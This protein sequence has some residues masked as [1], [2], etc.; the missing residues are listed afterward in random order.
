MAKVID[1]YYRVVVFWSDGTSRIVYFVTQR[2][3]FK[4]ALHKVLTDVQ[5]EEYRKFVY[6]IVCRI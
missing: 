3:K 6:Y 4:A 5:L 1:E 2:R